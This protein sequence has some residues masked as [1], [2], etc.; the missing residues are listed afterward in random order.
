MNTCDSRC[1]AALAIYRGDIPNNW[2]GKMIGDPTKT[3]TQNKIASY[4]AGT[5]GGGGTFSAI[6]DDAY[7]TGVGAFFGAVLSFRTLQFKVDGLGLGV[8]NHLTGYGAFNKPENGWELGYNWLFGV[9]PQSETFGDGDGPTKQLSNSKVMIGVKNQIACQIASGAIG[10]GYADK[11][12]HSL[13]GNLFSS[14][15]KLKTDFTDNSTVAYL[16]SYT[17]DWKVIGIDRQSSTA[18]VNF[19][20][21]NAST[22]TSA[23]RPPVIGYTSFWQHGFTPG[24]NAMFPLGS[25]SEKDQTFNFT[26]TFSFAGGCDK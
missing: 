8:L 15:G 4:E 5:G 24:F 1:Q 12:N 16:G 20:T 3:S 26:Q 11:A 2:Y 7:G 17:M 19:T 18:T 13:G 25:M 6:A 10:V 22:A 21:S 23:A 14:F 9:G